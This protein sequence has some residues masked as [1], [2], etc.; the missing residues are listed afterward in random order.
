[1]NGALEMDGF[2]ATFSDLYNV[3]GVCDFSS[4]TSTA[5]NGS[6]VGCGSGNGAG[7]DSMIVSKLGVL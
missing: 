7:S 6:E 1:M 5:G 4:S 2:K 3:S